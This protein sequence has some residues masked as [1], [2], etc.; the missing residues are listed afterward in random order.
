MT[1]SQNHLHKL[2]HGH[3]IVLNLFGNNNLLGLF[4]QVTIVPWGSTKKRHP[5]SSRI[6]FDW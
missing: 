4:D 5:A 3:T 1:T 2:Y 6:W